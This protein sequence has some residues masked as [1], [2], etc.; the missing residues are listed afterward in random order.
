MGLN[1]E[2][3]SKIINNSFKDAGKIGYVLSEIFT[4][5]VFEILGVN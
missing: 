5:I 2:G 1:L 4:M 3:F